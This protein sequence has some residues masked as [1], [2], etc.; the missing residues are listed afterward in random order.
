MT[1][2]NRRSLLIGACACATPSAARASGSRGCQARNS[3]RPSG[4]R[5]IQDIEAGEAIDQTTGDAALDR[6]LGRALLRMSDFFGVRP[7]VGVYDDST[8]PNALAY[9]AS[10]ISG[11]TGTVCL[12]ATLMRQLMAGSDDGGVSVVAVLA[13]EF[14]HIF[15]FQN[16]MDN[17]LAP[18]EG[19]VKLLELNADFF[20]GLFLAH[21]QLLVPEM[22]L[23]DSGRVFHGLGDTSFASSGHHGRPDERVRAIEFGH[24]VGRNRPDVRPPVALEESIRFVS[25]EFLR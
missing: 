9:K 19:P 5:S 20:A 18:G 10:Y 23:Y 1:L 22:R 15:Q 25:T 13:H 16:G 12:G 6:A 2:F 24:R 14:A 11:T 8:E 3:G 21:F 17:R 7:G 4:L